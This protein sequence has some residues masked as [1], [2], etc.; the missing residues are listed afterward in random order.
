MQIDRRGAALAAAFLL[1]ITF[2]SH[3]VAADPAVGSNAPDARVEDVDGRAVNLKSLKG[4]PLVLFYEGKESADQN[5]ALKD[6]I[7][8]LAKTEPYR[9]SLRLAAVGDVSD[10]DYWPAKGI[11]KD[12]IREESSR[13]GMPIFCDWDG[14][15]RSKLKL[16]RG[17]SNVLLIGADGRVLFTF[18]GAVKGAAKAALLSRLHAE[19]KGS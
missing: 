5:K 11:V 17:V 12:K 14:S 19:A 8:K 16:R 15:F 1:S 6:E 2:I 9:A 7:A 10:Y 18:A 4:K 3:T 13:R